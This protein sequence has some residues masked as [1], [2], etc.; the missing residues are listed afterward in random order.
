ML[1]S[2][3]RRREQP[4][5]AHLLPDPIVVDRAD[6]IDPEHEALLSDS[7]G[8]ALLVVLE[9]LTPAERLAYF[10]HD[11]FS[12]PFE[13]ILRGDRRHPRAL[14]RG[15]A[16]TRQPRPPPHPRCAHHDPPRRRRGRLGLSARRRTLRYRLPHGAQ[17]ADHDDGHP[18][19][20]RAP[21]PPRAH[22]L[23]RLPTMSRESNR[24]T[25]PSRVVWSPSLEPIGRKRL[26]TAH[27]NNQATS[28]LGPFLLCGLL[29]GW[30]NSANVALANLSRW[31]TGVRGALPFGG[32]FSTRP[33]LPSKATP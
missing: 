29:E 28:C 25:C 33:A 6:G 14:A 24:P 8:L 21:R 18:P 10:L 12:V 26:P 15:G 23:L 7:V 3:K 17:R 2:R 19:R 22:R 27:I 5:D 13:E 11:M 1:R 30:V 20:P 16:P 9:R 4:L 31:C 32:C